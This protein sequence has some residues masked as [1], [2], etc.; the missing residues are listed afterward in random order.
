MSDVLLTSDGE[1]VIV[2]CNFS[3]SHPITSVT[4]LYAIQTRVEIATLS[5]LA[6]TAAVNDG[7]AVK[8][9]RFAT[10]A[11]GF[12]SSM[13]VV[14]RVVRDAMHSTSLD[15]ATSSS[16]PTKLALPM[17]PESAIA[18]LTSGVLC[19]ATDVSAMFFFC[20]C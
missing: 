18:Q 20:K 9:L 10:A 17:S 11:N 8:A 15:L 5:E 6:L 1:R 16:K 19:Y 13:L 7:G 3:I 4:R 2:L 12:Q 14:T